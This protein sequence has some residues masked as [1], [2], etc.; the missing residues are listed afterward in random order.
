MNNTT[1]KEHDDLQN[2]IKGLADVSNQI[3]K[4]TNDLINSFKSLT[5]DCIVE[6]E[7]ASTFTE[8]DL[9]WISFALN[10]YMNSMTRNPSNPVPPILNDVAY[11]R[12]DSLIKKV[13]RIIKD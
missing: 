4:A 11:A 10:Y 7:N 8:E 6:S 1:E 12:I 5:N 9:V 13:N 3:Q 2:S